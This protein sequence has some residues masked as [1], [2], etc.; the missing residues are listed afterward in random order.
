[1]D[2]TMMDRHDNQTTKDSADDTHARIAEV[3]EGARVRLTRNSVVD[4][5]SLQLCMCT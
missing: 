5:C 2:I 3:P 1:M 4:N